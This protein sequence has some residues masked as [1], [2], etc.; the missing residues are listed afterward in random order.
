MDNFVRR[1]L[2][3]CLAVIS[4][5]VLALGVPAC[6]GEPSET[7]KPARRVEKDPRTYALRN[8]SITGLKLSLVSEAITNQ[9]DTNWTP[10]VIAGKVENKG[11]RDLASL[12][13]YY[14]F[15]W[16]YEE[17]AGEFEIGPLAAKESTQVDERVEVILVHGMASVRVPYKL[18]LES[19]EFEFQSEFEL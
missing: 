7:G 15:E 13:V 16:E 2:G 19:A 3:L 12:V 5:A 17:Y 14:E 4:A 10:I 11:D 6:G 18:N 1:A 8:A 9:Y